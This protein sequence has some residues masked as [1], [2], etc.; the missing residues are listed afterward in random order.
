M[1]VYSVEEKALEEKSKDLGSSLD[2]IITKLHGKSNSVTMI[3]C[4]YT[5]GSTVTF[6]KNTNT[7]AWPAEIRT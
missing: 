4:G 2:Y 6:L 7:Q 1:Q 3:F 5:A